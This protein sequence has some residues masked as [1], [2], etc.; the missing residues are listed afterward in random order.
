MRLELLPIVRFANSLLVCLGLGYAAESAA[1]GTVFAY[2]FANGSQ[3]WSA[4][5]ADYPAGEEEFYK[6]A[7]DFARL[8]KPLQ[9]GRFALRLGGN[10]HSDDLCM[11]LRKKVGGLK[12]NTDYRVGFNV[13]LASN[14]PNGAI[15]VGGAPAESVYVKAGVSLNRPA[16]DP[17]TRLLNID[18]GNQ[19]AEG[20][21][22]INLGHIGVDT[23]AENPKY[24]LK[25]LD[26]RDKPFLFRTDETGTA[27]LFFATDSGFEGFTQIYAVAYG[28]QFSEN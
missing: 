24:R 18:K 13:V 9:T 15:G 5:F 12:P 25:I 8:P 10:N 11:F 3:G 20:K 19:A 26:N 21:D 16:A 6:L 23:P 2:N 1:A 28:A 7:Y 17:S 14:A 4:D 27:W 22:A